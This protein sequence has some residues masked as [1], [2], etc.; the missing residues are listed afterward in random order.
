MSLS[1]KG[2]GGLP[3]FPL[4]LF[5]LVFF[6]L[7]LAAETCSFRKASILALS[8]NFFAHSEKGGAGVCKGFGGVGDF[9]LQRFAMKLPKI[10]F[11]VSVR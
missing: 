5:V 11:G 6:Y 1:K 8:T 9:L 4:G 10:P 2:G 7:F 3:V